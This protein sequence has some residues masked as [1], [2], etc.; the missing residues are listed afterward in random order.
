MEEPK[1]FYFGDLQINKQLVI[2]EGELS[3]AFMNPSPFLPGHVIVTPKS[4][5]RRLHELAKAEFCDLFL[6]AKLVGSCLKNSCDALSIYVKDG[7]VAGQDVDVAHIHV[8]PRI[9]ADLENNNDIYKEDSL[10]VGECN[11]DLEHLKDQARKLRR[12]FIYAEL[13]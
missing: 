4:R 10:R 11:T 7:R 1:I 6:V 9:K 5:R 3:I 12:L 8:V 13:G 2:F